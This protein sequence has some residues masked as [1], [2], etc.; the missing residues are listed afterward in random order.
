M[1]EKD[2]PGDVIDF[3][4]EWRRRR[5][6]GRAVAEFALDKCEEMFRHCDWQGFGYWLAVYRRER[7]AGPPRRNRL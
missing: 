3:F 4:W 1:M 2:R 6:G 5:D 7:A